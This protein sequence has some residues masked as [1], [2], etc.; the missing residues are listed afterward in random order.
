VSPRT[1]ILVMGAY[2]VIRSLARPRGRRSWLLVAAVYV[3]LI[4][5]GRFYFYCVSVGIGNLGGEQI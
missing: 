4:L 5:C 3:V 2:T 1:S